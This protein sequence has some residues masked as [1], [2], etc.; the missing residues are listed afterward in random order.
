MQTKIDAASSNLVNVA[1]SYSN[2][3][4]AKKLYFNPLSKLAR[5]KA[6]SAINSYMPVIAE[7]NP[8]AIESDSGSYLL[9]KNG[10]LI[11]EVSS[12]KQRL[13]VN[14][15]I[16]N[17][18]ASRGYNTDQTTV[19]SEDKDQITFEACNESGQLG[20]LTLIIDLGKGLL[21]DEHYQEEIDDFRDQKTSVCEVSKLAFNPSSSS[22]EIF[23]SLFH[24]AYLYAYC[25]YGVKN[26]F[27]EINPRHAS[28]YKRM[29]G[30][31]Q[32]GEERVCKRVDAPAVLL[33][34]DLEFMQKRILRNQA[35]P[36]ISDKSIYSY[37]LSQNEEQDILRTI[38]NQPN[39]FY[40]SK[41]G[42]IPQSQS[43]FLKSNKKTI[44]VF[45]GLFTEIIK[46]GGNIKMHKSVYC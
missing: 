28:F 27:I 32:I 42:S 23:A 21:A 37:F 24:V 35:T 5:T 7:Q 38:Q 43:L 19:F 13:K 3:Q 12:L 44:D 1:Q 40:K 22:K 11:R 41:I 17:R 2:N 9:K 45:Y 10:Y 14:S 46:E 26:A 29:L 31:E 30:F 15:L 33:R 25:T 4:L 36:S 20:T 34:L 16:K 39:G 8:F 6:T 18:Y